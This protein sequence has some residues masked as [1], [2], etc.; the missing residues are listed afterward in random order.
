MARTWHRLMPPLAQRRLTLIIAVALLLQ[1]MITNRESYIWHYMGTYSLGLGLLAGMS[2]RWS[3][4]QPR[5]A[6]G[7]LLALLAVSLFYAP[8]WM[9]VP[10]SE[11]ELRM[12][13]IFPLWR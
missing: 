1:W 7:A 4:Q 11:T 3:Q 12:R 10:L 6:G 8:V 2:A 13:L 5:A 9:N